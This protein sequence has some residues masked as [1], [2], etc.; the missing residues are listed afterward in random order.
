MDEIDTQFNE[1][2]IRIFRQEVDTQDIVLV[3]SHTDGSSYAYLS[4]QQ[5][6]DVIAVLQK[7]IEANK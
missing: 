7:Q 6:Q 1:T 5:A 2:T 3:L 4:T